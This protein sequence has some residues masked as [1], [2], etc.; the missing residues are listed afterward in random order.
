M[1]PT[2]YD[3]EHLS[4]LTGCKRLKIPHF[5][6]ATCVPARSSENDCRPLP[7]VERRENLALERCL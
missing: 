4:L 5:D 3:G 7:L 2:I 1:K 6:L